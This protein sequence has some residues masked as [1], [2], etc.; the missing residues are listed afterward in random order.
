[1]AKLCTTLVPMAVPEICRKFCPL[2]WKLVLVR[3]SFSKFM[4][5]LLL[6]L[7]SGRGLDWLR[8]SVAASRRVGWLMFV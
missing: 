5:D 6:G 8:A 4:S 2:N 7:T 3:T 1:M